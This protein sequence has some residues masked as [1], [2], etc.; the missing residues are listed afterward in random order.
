MAAIVDGAIQAHE[1]RN[2]FVLVEKRVTAKG[3]IMLRSL[4][5]RLNEQHYLP[6]LKKSGPQTFRVG[7]AF[8]RHFRTADRS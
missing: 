1:P 7:A 2:Y 6:G 8:S 3:P 4:I 5:E